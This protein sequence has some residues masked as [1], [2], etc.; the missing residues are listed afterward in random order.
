MSVAAGPPE[1]RHW[2]WPKTS[3]VKTL[4]ALAEIERLCQA[5]NRPE[6]R[7]DLNHLIEQIKML[8][9]DAQGRP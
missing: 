1:G 6:S 9:W 3:Y 7:E 8:A 2:Y 4:V 5:M